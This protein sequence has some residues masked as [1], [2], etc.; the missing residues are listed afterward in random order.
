MGQHGGVGLN[1]VLRGTPRQQPRPPDIAPLQKAEANYGQKLHKAELW[2]HA[3]A[4]VFG[5]EGSGARG[6]SEAQR[7]RIPVAMLACCMG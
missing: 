5:C 7:Q 4:A 3:S 1:D 6:A 2:L